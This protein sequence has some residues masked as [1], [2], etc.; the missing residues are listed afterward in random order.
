MLHN[1]Y[2]REDDQN[3]LFTVQVRCRPYLSWY[4]VYWLLCEERCAKRQRQ[5]H[6]RQ[7][8]RCCLVHINLQT[9][10][11]RSLGESSRRG[12]GWSGQ[13]TESRIMSQRGKV[14]CAGGIAGGL[15]SAINNATTKHWNPCRLLDTLASLHRELSERLDSTPLTEERIAAKL[16]PEV[17][18]IGH[19]IQCA[20]IGWRRQ[21]WRLCFWLWPNGE[22]HR[23][24]RNWRSILKSSLKRVKIVKM[25]L[26]D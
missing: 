5:Q 21:L 2:A 16:L 26:A 13:W 6:R 20:S 4:P 22:L 9:W 19:D 14:A 3:L 25:F 7:W 15:P 24:V 23:F 8:W 11:W 17:A 1:R 12:G 18:R 10:S